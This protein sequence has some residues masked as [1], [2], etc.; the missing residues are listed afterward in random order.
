[1]WR[2]FITM[3]SWTFL[4]PLVSMKMISNTPIQVLHHYWSFHN[5][6]FR[7]ITDAKYLGCLMMTHIR[8]QDI[9]MVTM[10]FLL[11][12]WKWEQLSLQLIKCYFHQDGSRF[13]LIIGQHKY[14]RWLGDI[15]HLLL[16]LV[17][18]LLYFL[19]LLSCSYTLFDT[20]SAT[21]HWIWLYYPLWHP[22]HI[23][24]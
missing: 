10:C 18:D 15:N 23:N 19:P 14:N 1:M 3:I 16:N 11:L 8:F 5:S 20:M 12:W 4:G 21:M 7:W 6:Y 9:Q 13:E 22:K 2:I 24:I 17:L